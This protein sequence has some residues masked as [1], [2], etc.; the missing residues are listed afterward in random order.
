MNV[1]KGHNRARG[2]LGDI[3]GMIDVVFL[4]I[5]FFLT[6][7]SLA[8]LN[9][10]PVDLP[11]LEGESTPNPEDRPVVINLTADGGIIVDR[12]PLTVANLPTRRA[13]E[14]ESRGGDPA[15]GT[16]LGRADRA[17]V[18]R[19]VDAIAGVLVELGIASWSVGTAIPR[20][21]GGE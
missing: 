2:V 6:T 15:I 8:R 11:E 12:A 1:N 14:I 3:T 10:A 4:L 18:V 21:G 9:A 16:V 13:A 17:A 19:D 5:I 20:N 7:S